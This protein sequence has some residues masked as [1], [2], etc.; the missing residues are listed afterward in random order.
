MEIKKRTIYE[1]NG[2]QYKYYSEAEQARREDI[3]AMGGFDCD[4][5]DREGN[6][7][8]FVEILE[9]EAPED[10]FYLDTQS[11][12]VVETLK[13]LGKRMLVPV[14]EK[15]GTWLWNEDEG[16]YCSPQQ[17]VEKLNDRWDKYGARFSFTLGL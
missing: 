13:E 2:K 14:P 9:R 6:Q 12:Q 1:Y 5:R 10:V 16:E 7:I 8:P 15:V 4:I 3:L 17:E 11:Q